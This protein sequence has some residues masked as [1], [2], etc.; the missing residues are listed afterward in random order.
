M[1]IFFIALKTI[2]TLRRGK[3][4]KKIRL[5]F[6]PKNE[7]SRFLTVFL[8]MHRTKIRKID[9]V[10]WGAPEPNDT[11]FSFIAILGAVESEK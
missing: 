6:G 4:R 11:P 9:M 8:K 1:V 7:K 5:I 2:C 3:K 10:G